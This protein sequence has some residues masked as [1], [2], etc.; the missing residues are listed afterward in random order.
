MAE[1]ELFEP[2]HLEVLDQ[3]VSRLPNN[4]LSVG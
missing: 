3:C 4:V 2:A 1:L